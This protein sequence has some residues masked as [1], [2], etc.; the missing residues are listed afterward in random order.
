[1]NRRHIAA[2]LALCILGVAARGASAATLKIATVVPAGTSFLKGLRKAGDE[3]SQRT[4]GRVSLKLFPGGVMGDD[5]SVLRK[6]KIGQLDGAVVSSGG[7]SLIH[8]DA[9]VYSLPFVFRNYDEVEYVRKRIDPVIRKRVRSKGYV[10]AGISEG[11]FTYLFSKQPLRKLEDLRNAKVWVPEGDEITARMF[12]NAGAQTVSLPISDVFTSLQ[13]GLIDTVTIN[14]AGAIALQW[15]TGVSYQTDAPLL[16][17]TGMLVFQQHALA[18]LQPDD[19]DTVLD[20]M[21][22]TF[23][24]LDKVNRTDNQQAMKALRDQGIK[25][26]EPTRPPAQRRWVDIA[27]K[28]LK[29]LESEGSFDG[30]L[31]DRVHGLVDQYRRQ[32]GG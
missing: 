12:S 3:I 6:M 32:H 21:R 17:L 15:H 29:N 2:I 23:H 24:H 14:P 5:R 30:K 13:T 9:Q 7:I 31:L 8:P 10:L 27:R 1:M 4:D 28:T 26:V 22:A 16:F 20:V 18:R 11:G 19:R 25:L